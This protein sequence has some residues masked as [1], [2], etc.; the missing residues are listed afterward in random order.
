[1]KNLRADLGP[2]TCCLRVGLVFSESPIQFGGQLGRQRQGFIERVFGDCIPQ[3]LDELQTFRDRHL[4]EFVEVDRTLGHGSQGE[5]ARLSK[6][7][8]AGA[9]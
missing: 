1:M 4:S 7:A 9:C 2:P 3:V 5:A 6:Q 8:M